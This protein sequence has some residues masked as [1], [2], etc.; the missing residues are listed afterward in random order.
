MQAGMAAAIACCNS[1]VVPMLELLLLW[2]RRLR[3][4]LLLVQC[5]AELTYEDSQPKRGGLLPAAHEHVVHIGHWISN[6][7]PRCR[8]A[9]YGLWEDAHIADPTAANQVLSR[10]ICNLQVKTAWTCVFQP[11]CVLLAALA[12]VGPVGQFACSTSA[13]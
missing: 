1:P 12:T 7:K 9:E 11:A 8:A 4:L 2:L 5:A 10:G 6:I 3:L 13:A